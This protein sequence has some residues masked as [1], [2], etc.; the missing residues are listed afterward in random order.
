MSHFAEPWVKGGAIA[1]IEAKSGNVVALA[2]IPRFDPNDFISG[3]WSAQSK[4]LESDDYLAALGTG[5]CLCAVRLVD[6]RRSPSSFHGVFYLHLILPENHPVRK[7]LGLIS[8]ITSLAKT[9]NKSEPSDSYDENLF[10]DLAHLAV[11]VKRFTPYLIDHLPKRSIDAHFKDKGHFQRIESFVCQTSRA[12][13]HET[14]FAQFREESGKAFLQE[15]RK[16][17][18]EKKTYARPYTTYLRAKEKELFEAFWK[19]HR[20]ELCAAFLQGAGSPSPYSKCLKKWADE[21]G[22]WSAQCARVGK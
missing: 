19:V 13:F 9:L 12:I 1:A 18:R 22:E 6:H 16:K 8:D 2:S 10:L 15:M 3:D 7:R 4:W 14:E 11:D 21:V 20:L 5:A 17:E